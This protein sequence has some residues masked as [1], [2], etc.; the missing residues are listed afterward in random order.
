MVFLVRCKHN[1]IYTINVSAI[2]LLHKTGCSCW[3][4]TSILEDGDGYKTVGT[5]VCFPLHVI[6]MLVWRQKSWV[7]TPPSQP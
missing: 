1:S 7:L 4:W 3:S 6:S 2:D 5:D